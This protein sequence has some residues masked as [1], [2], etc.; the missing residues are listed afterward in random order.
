[1]NQC[2]EISLHMGEW[3]YCFEFLLKD[4]TSTA[5]LEKLYNE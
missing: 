3:E 2:D 1:M 4:G 5:V